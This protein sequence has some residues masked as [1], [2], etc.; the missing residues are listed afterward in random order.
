M[1]WINARARRF[2]GSGG[3]TDLADRLNRA[4]AFAPGE[5]VARIEAVLW[6]ARLEATDALVQVGGLILDP[7]SH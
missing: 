7:K 2:Y 4:Q 6:R 5:L 3:S 1:T